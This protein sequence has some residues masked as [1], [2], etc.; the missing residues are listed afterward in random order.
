M[1][2]FSVPVVN[3]DTK[4]VTTKLQLVVGETV[5][6]IRNDKKCSWGISTNGVAAIKDYD[7]DC[8]DGEFG[9]KALKQG[10][11]VVYSDVSGV[12]EFH[13]IQVL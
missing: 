10:E 2:K 3:L 13:I 9:V 4:V 7:V 1:A 8:E 12:R 11:A 6:L 5:K